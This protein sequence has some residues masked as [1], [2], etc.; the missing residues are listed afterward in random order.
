MR[1]ALVMRRT[2]LRIFAI[3]SCACGNRDCSEAGVFRSPPPC[4]A[5]CGRR[6]EFDVFRAEV[7][8]YQRFVESGP[9]WVGR[10]RSP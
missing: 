3:W 7:G 2:R 6:M 5:S 10:G 1:A 8:L 9:F 4:S